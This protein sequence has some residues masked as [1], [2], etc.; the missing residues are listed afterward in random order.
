MTGTT[1]DNGIID[2]NGLSMTINAPTFNMHDPDTQIDAF[3]INSNLTLN[4]QP[5]LTPGNVGSDV[6]IG[7][8]SQLNLPSGVQQHL[9]LLPEKQRPISSRTAPLRSPA[10]R[11]W[12]QRCEHQR[13][14]PP[15]TPRST[16]PDMRTCPAAASSTATPPPLFP[17][18]PSSTSTVPYFRVHRLEQRHLHQRGRHLRQLERQ[19]RHRFLERGR[20]ASR[21]SASPAAPFSTGRHFRAPTPPSTSRIRGARR[22][23]DEHPAAAG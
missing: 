8:N 18:T 1:A 9:W 17:P 19:H 16:S 15:I 13:V 21:R 23:R 22:L 4:G 2:A 14:R 10:V 12:P 7:N 11:R 20:P 6:T 3:G 5:D